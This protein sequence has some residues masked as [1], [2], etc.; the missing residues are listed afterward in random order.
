MRYSP[1]MSSPEEREALSPA[2]VGWGQSPRYDSYSGASG[3]FLS[4]LRPPRGLHHGALG[5]GCQAPGVPAQPAA[6]VP[7]ASTV[8]MH[9]CTKRG[10]GLRSRSHSVA[11][12]QPN[13]WS[14]GEARQPAPPSPGPPAP[15]RSPGPSGTFDVA[16]V[17]Q[18]LQGRPPEQELAELVPDLAQVAVLAPRALGGRSCHRERG[19]SQSEA[20]RW[21]SRSPPCCHTPPPPPKMPSALP[22]LHPRAHLLPSASHPPAS[23]PGAPG[24]RSPSCCSR[25]PPR[26]A[27]LWTGTAWPQRQS[28][29]PAGVLPRWGEGPKSPRSRPGDAP[30][31]GLTLPLTR[32]TPPPPPGSLKAFTFLGRAELFRC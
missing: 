22:P 9:C 16:L 7:R 26:G 19:A 27:G 29:G 28:L 12:A 3:L 13:T 4:T 5:G 8:R 23:F 31:A 17:P 30:P 18:R 15:P 14:G 20:P 25:F 11:S 6:Y 1:S 2:L 24:T 21:P 10:T 32:L